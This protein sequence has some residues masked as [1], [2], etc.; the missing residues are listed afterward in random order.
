MALSPN[1]WQNLLV[2]R[3][4]RSGLLI[5]AAIFDLKM[6]IKKCCCCFNLHTGVQVLAIIFALSQL[7][8]IIGLSLKLSEVQNLDP[9]PTPLGENGPALKKITECK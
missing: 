5:H 4:V 2:N 8:S 1:T 7:S 9:T 3:I 6:A